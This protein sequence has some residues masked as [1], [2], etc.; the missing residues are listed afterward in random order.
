M[1]DYMKRKEYIFMIVLG[2]VMTL[3]MF[4]KMCDGITKFWT[5]LCDFTAMIG[6]GILCS[7]IVSYVIDKQNK[8]R[9]Q[10]DR[11]EQRKYI[12][13]SVKNNFMRLFERELFEIS[14]Y[15]AKYMMEYSGSWKKKKFPCL[16]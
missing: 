11:E 7:T 14:D 4:I 9:E 6:G 3:A 10:R 1:R 15:Y 12:F 13:S 5:I 2:L 16:K 8:K